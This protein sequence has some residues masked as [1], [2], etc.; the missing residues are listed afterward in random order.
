MNEKRKELFR[1]MLTVGTPECAIFFGA[2]A[3]VLA[4]FFLLLGFWRT[5]LIALLVGAGA[6]VG[7]VK[8]KKGCVSRVI[9]R[10]FP[11]KTAMPYR[12]RPVVTEQTEQAACGTEEADEPEASDQ[13]DTGE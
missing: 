11:P 3:M 6:F 5:L 2:A 9:N 1:Q 12:E 4:L 8:D 10:L 13:S 7:G